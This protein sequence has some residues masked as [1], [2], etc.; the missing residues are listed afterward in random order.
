[1][2]SHADLLKALLPPFSYDLAG[3]AIAA[4][5][6]AEGAALDDALAASLRVLSAITPDGDTGLLPDW[7]RVYGL[8]DACLADVESS[9]SSRVAAVIDKIRR[10]GG[11][12][13]QFFIDLAA[14]L[15]Y[16]ITITEFAPLTVSSPVTYSVYDTD[17]QYYWQVNLA[18]DTPPRPITVLDSVT[19]PLVVYQ[20]GLLECLLH[21][22]KPAHTELLFAYT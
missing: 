12:S 2:N 5:L 4:Q 6:E 11:L 18:T 1:M 19:T 21:K 14:A 17:S 7:E 20:T 15:G 13:R 16:A 22:L 10:G 8:P 9:V 3:P